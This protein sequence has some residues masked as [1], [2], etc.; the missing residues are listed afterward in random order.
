[1]ST[2]TPH[3]TKPRRDWLAFDRSDRWGFA[4]MLGLGVVATT[5]TQVVVPLVGWARGRQLAVPFVSDVDV[6][7]LPT[8]HLD[9]RNPADYELLIADPSTRQRLLDL[10]P[11][12]GYVVVVAALAWLLF[13]LM[14][15]I[16]RGDPF[17]AAN[18]RRLRQMAGLL[19]VGWTVVYFAEATCSFAILAG[20]DLDGT[21]LAGGPRTVLTLPIVPFVLGVI[22]AL[23]AEAFKA[24]SRLQDDVAGLV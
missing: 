4:V 14:R 6:A 24:G 5:L 17:A 22:A 21:G 10:L 13:R 7:G 1:M 15:S 8:E 23:V 3:P 18:V 16:G 12:L 2:S 9:Y 11:G 20:V 19:A